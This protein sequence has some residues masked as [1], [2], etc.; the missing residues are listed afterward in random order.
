MDFMSLFYS[1]THVSMMSLFQLVEQYLRQARTLISTHKQSNASAAL[2]LIQTAL[3]LSPQFEPALELKA[4]SL[5]ILR[6]YQDI[7][8]MLQD[9]IP[10]CYKSEEDSLPGSSGS[11]FSLSGGGGSGD[12]AAIGWAKLLSPG[13]ERSAN[14]NGSRPFRCFSVSDLKHRV[15]AGISP[16]GEEEGMWRY[17]FLPNP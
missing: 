14:L 15:F 13:R 17:I 8:D 9:Y 1:A 16:N 3:S 7:A 5:L 2:N 12:L 6:R 11:G 10:S 4:R